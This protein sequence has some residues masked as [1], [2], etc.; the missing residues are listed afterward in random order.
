[1]PLILNKTLKCPSQLST[2]NSRLLKSAD[3]LTEK[4]GCH[5]DYVDDNGMESYL[6]VGKSCFPSPW[7]IIKRGW[8]SLS[9]TTPLTPL[10]TWVQQHC[11]TQRRTAA[12]LAV[13]M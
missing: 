7:Q 9:R 5:L 11:D 8:I 10:F 12:A 13:R 3:D 4:N 2:L 1:M 6:V